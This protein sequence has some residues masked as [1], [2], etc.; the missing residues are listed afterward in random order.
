[1]AGYM[2]APGPALHTCRRGTGSL[3]KTA[4]VSV[5]QYADSLF[6]AH[7]LQQRQTS[8]CSARLA[9][10]VSGVCADNET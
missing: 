2:C 8:M 7:K 3:A 6:N 5:L 9:N 4:T 1:M 10:R